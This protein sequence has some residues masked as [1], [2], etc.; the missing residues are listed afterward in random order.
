MSEEHTH[1][2]RR[3]QGG[4]VIRHAHPVRIIK[5]GGGLH[6]QQDVLQRR[7]I[8]TRAVHIARGYEAGQAVRGDF[9]QR[10]ADRLQ[11]RDGVVLEVKEEAIPAKALE[12][13]VQ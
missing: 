4:G 2:F 6:A 9:G 11:L 5:S 7:I 13:E 1:L 12:V 10:L 3:T 8:T